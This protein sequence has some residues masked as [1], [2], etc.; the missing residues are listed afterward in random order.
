MDISQSS[1]IC[2]QIKESTGFEFTVRDSGI[3]GVSVI[4]ANT[5]TEANIL[6]GTL[7]EQNIVIYAEPIYIRSFE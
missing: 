6:V 7:N 5:V 4:T 3:Q 1:L 2:E